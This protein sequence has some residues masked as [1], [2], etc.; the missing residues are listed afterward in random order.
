MHQNAHCALEI[1]PHASH[2]HTKKKKKK[3]KKSQLLPQLQFIYSSNSIVLD[4]LK[5]IH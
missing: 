3:K 2:P 1:S 4:Y 5:Y